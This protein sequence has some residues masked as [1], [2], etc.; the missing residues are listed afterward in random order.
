MPS[1]YHLLT[2]GAYMW[3]LYVVLICG[4]YMWCTYVVLVDEVQDAAETEGVRLKAAL[5]ICQVFRVS[6]LGF[7]VSGFGFKV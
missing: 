7:R 1:R 6:G 3:C 2:C 5:A 4:A